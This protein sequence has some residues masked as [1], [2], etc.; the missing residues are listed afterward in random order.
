MEHR[1]MVHGTCLLFWLILLAFS[2]FSRWSLVSIIHYPL[3]IAH[4]PIAH[5]LPIVHPPPSTISPDISETKWWEA[6]KEIGNKQQQCK[7]HKLFLY[8]LTIV[9]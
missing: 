1:S 6:Y 2:S 7:T 3:S 9:T 5:C 8:K 4:S